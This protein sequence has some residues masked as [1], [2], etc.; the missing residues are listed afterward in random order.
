MEYHSRIRVYHG[1]ASWTGTCA[2][3]VLLSN[4][5]VN[6]V[7]DGLQEVAVPENCGSRRNITGFVFVT[8]HG[9]PD[10]LTMQENG[11]EEWIPES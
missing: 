4:L 10:S 3:V 5:Q 11:G 6:Q 1:Y 8:I 2:T 7:R 9:A